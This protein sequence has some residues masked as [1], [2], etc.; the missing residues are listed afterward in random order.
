MSLSRPTLLPTRFAGV[1]LASLTVATAVAIGSGADATKQE[2][3]LQTTG[4]ATVSARML[5]NR[6]AARAIRTCP[7]DLY[8]EGLRLPAK[9]APSRNLGLSECTRNPE[10][11]YRA[12]V[13]GNV[14][15]ACFRLGQ[16]FEARG[17]TGDNLR[18]QTLFALAC[19][20]GDGAGCTNRAAGLRNGRFPGDPLLGMPAQARLSC[21]YRSFKIDC[22]LGGAWGCAMLGQAYRLGEGVAPDIRLAREAY[23]RACSIAPGFDACEF[24]KSDLSPPGGSD[25]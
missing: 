19:A 20:G 5:L 6:K 9:Q 18:K 8:E 10:R 12:C 11:C 25:L 21:T 13:S 22:E 4:A 7:A 3:P 1:L 2:A 23:R 17:R 16:A 24:G 15:E 14:G